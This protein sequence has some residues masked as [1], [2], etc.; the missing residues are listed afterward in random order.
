MELDDLIR[1]AEDD[2]EG[3]EPL[4]RLSS[5]M[6]VKADLD[7]LTDALIGH[8]VDQARRAG[9]SWSEIGAAMGVTKQA[10]QQRHTAEEPGR[11]R[12][13]FLPTFQRFTPR[14]RMAVRESEDAA[15]ELRHAEV[16]AEHVLLGLLSVSEGLAAKSLESMGVTRARV[17]AELDAGEQTGRRRKVPFAPSAKHALEGALQEAIGLAH[18]YIGTEHLLLAIFR[19]PDSRAATLLGELGVDAAKVRADV[20]ARI[21]K[22]MAS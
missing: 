1:Q 12:G 16:G 22:M 5:A 11:G 21:T 7:D 20:L 10:A 13:R 6:G 9:H 8:F 19:E 17:V 4:D 14:A 18:N 15:R 2:A 3:S